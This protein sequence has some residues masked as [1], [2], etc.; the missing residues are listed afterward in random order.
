MNNETSVFISYAHQDSNT[1][2]VSAFY[3]FLHDCLPKKVEILLDKKKLGIG[4]N[5]AN[6]VQRLESCP[7]AVVLLTPDYKRRVEQARNGVFDEYQ[8]IRRR[9]LDE[10]DEFLILTVLF[11]G[12]PAT[13]I[14]ALLNREI[15]LDLTFFHPRENDNG[16]YRF[17][18]TADQRKKYIPLFTALGRAIE[19]K[20][21]VRNLSYDKHEEFMELLFAKTK[22]TREA[23]RLNPQY[24]KHLFV[25][26]RSY[27]R[28]KSQKALFLIG[29]K[30]SGK[31]TIANTLPELEHEKYKT[32]IP[33]L[34]DHINLLSTYELIDQVK[35]STTYHAIGHRLG[36]R[37]AEYTQLN[38]MQF[39]FKY[40]WLG[41]IYICLAMEL[42][43]L[44]DEGQLNEKQKEHYPA[45]KKHLD[46]FTFGQGEFI[47]ASLYYTTASVAF[48]DFWDGVVSRALTYANYTDLV[49]YLDSY[50]NSERYL[51][52]LLGDT[53]LTSI[54]GI[55]T[56]CDRRALVTLDDF[57]SAFSMFRSAVGEAQAKNSEGDAPLSLEA[58]WI[59]ALMILVLEMKGLRR[60]WSDQ[61][62]SKLDFCITIPKDAYSQVLH[63]DR[64]AYFEL[65]CTSDLDWT[66]VDLA[67]MLLKRLCFV[68]DEG[69]DREGNLFSEL[70]RVVHLYLPNLPTTL[71]FRFNA[72]HVS[73]DLF[74]YVLRHTFWRPRD[75]LSYYA[76]LMVA[77]FSCDGAE[78]MSVELIR[79]VVGRNTRIVLDF[80]FYNEF[81]DIIKN[82]SSITG[83]FYQQK[84]ILSYSEVHNIL[85]G[86][87]FHLYSR[88]V[89][90]D[91]DTKLRILYELG[92][93]GI[94]LTEDL[95]DSEQCSMQCF[96]F[97][98]GLAIFNSMARYTFAN[99]NFLVH[100]I[101]VEELQ[102]RHTQNE[103]ILHWTEEYLQD[104]H[105]VRSSILDAG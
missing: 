87:A 101:F 77:S 52:H 70:R 14:P 8:T 91:F 44:G 89:I 71:D 3:Q 5:I 100:P 96:C 43:K 53:L 85:S 15:Y 78:Q 32:C 75:V 104:N 62:F 102:I 51:S 45:L 76:A 90:K 31:S 46:H 47:E 92:F 103:L 23:V 39:L 7:V 73:I 10:N 95:A 30:G 50:V 67:R 12:T 38:P 37:A 19:T 64:D 63:A 94:E 93:L 20:I 65:E 69:S 59:Q 27:T 56:N 98:E 34:A 48:C 13:S 99:C 36:G 11:E 57:D 26:T 29:R 33:V 60:G 55:V 83:L 72:H 74:S 1:N 54:R 41:L 81:K 21:Q 40:A 4:T 35:L 25:R 2:R 84:Q 61:I 82:L 28:V 22:I 24:Y 17:E 88:G 79:Q 80:E 49:R 42:K 86:T 16:R 66:G 68:Y 97:N 18:L 6:F 9:Y 58:S 105:V